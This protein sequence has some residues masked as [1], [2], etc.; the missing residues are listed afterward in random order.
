A[1]A[2]TTLP[3]LLEVSGN[4]GVRLVSLLGTS[5]L[6]LRWARVTAERKKIRDRALAEQVKSFCFANRPG[7]GSYGPFARLAGSAGGRWS[8]PRLRAATAAALQ[9]DIALKTTR[10][11]DEAGVVTDLVLSLAASR[12]KRAAAV[13][14]TL[15]VL[16]LG[17]RPAGAQASLLPTSPRFKD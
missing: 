16:W 11:S 17:V 13:V 6:V 7:V 8:L 4:S 1:R 5:L 3:D 15:L 12:V 2:L 9:A 10:I 14:A